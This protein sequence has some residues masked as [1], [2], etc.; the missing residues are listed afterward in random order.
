M[1]D[2]AVLLHV[3]RRVVGVRHRRAH[4]ARLA[5]PEGL[6]VPR[7]GLAHGGEGRGRTPHRGEKLLHHGR[8]VRW[9]PRL[10]GHVLH[11]QQAKGAHVAAPTT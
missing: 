6:P 10:V 8:D 11:E 4:P 2:V 3:L 7:G 9:I 5:V 1:P